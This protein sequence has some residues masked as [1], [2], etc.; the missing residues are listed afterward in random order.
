MM[1][2]Y[3]TKSFWGIISNLSHYPHECTLLI[4]QA[5]SNFPKEVYISPLFE[6]Q[7]TKAK[8]TSQ[9]YEGHNRFSTLIHLVCG[10][11]IEVV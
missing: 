7:A 1:K 6:I 9:S 4:N 3:M 11:S 8:E 10:P 2:C 5:H